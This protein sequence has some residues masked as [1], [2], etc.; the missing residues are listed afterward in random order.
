MNLGRGVHI[1]ATLWLGATLLVSSGCGYKNLPV[2]P[3]SVVPVAVQ[4]LR[5]VVDDKGVKLSWTF[6]YCFFASA[7]TTIMERTA[8]ATRTQ[9]VHS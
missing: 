3:E 8:P 6:R 2:P 7:R 4:D 9:L 1:A 5:Y